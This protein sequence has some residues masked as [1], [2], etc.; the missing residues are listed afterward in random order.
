MGQKDGNYL[1]AV[2]NN[3]IVRGA[4]VPALRDILCG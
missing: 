3:D 4:V 1:A 2:C